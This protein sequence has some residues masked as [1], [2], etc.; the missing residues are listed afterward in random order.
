MTTARDV[1]SDRLSVLRPEMT[2]SDAVRLLVED[3]ISGAPVVDHQ[4]R[5]VGVVSKTDLLERCLEGRASP[6]LGA[7]FLSFLSLDA[8]TT[9]DAAMHAEIEALGTVED[10]MSADVVTIAADDPLWAVA[11]AMADNR[12][13]RVVVLDGER[14]VGIVS[15][16]DLLAHWPTPVREAD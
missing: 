4:S 16:L 11:A 13:H 12:V 15:T 14:P 7:R 3:G 2:V 5:L 10:L 8:G 1:M 6:E 9:A